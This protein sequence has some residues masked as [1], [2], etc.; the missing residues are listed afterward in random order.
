[1][2][3]GWPGFGG[4]AV[5]ATTTGLILI[6]ASTALVVG[7]LSVMVIGALTGDKRAPKRC[8]AMQAVGDLMGAI[9]Q[10]IIA[11]RVGFWIGV[12]FGAWMTWLWWKAGGD[13]DTRKRRRQLRDWVKSHIPKPVIVAIR[14]TPAGVAA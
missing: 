5:T 4:G 6:A 12:F 3:Q 9:G 10:S 11:N 14:T 7:G 8:Y 13:D 2:A 1:V